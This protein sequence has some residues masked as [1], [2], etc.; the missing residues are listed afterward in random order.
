MNTD[1]NSYRSA[2]MMLTEFS[3]TLPSPTVKFWP[4]FSGSAY[5]YIW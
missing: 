3:A 4:K 5:K 2:A 1:A